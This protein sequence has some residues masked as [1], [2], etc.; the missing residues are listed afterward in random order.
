MASDS[1]KGV[2]NGLQVLTHQLKLL[3]SLIDIAG[4]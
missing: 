3:H 2:G 4:L 1:P